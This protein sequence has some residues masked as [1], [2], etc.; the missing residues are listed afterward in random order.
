MGFTSTYSDIDVTDQY[1][2]T[3]KY[4]VNGFYND[5]TELGLLSVFCFNKWLPVA[6]I[7]PKH[8]QKVFDKVG[9]GALYLVHTP[10]SSGKKSLFY[11][12]KTGKLLSFDKSKKS[13]ISISQAESVAERMKNLASH[14]K[15][16]ADI[17]LLA[18][19]VI[20]SKLQ[21]GAS[22][23]LYRFTDNSWEKQETK[24]VVN[25]KLSFRSLYQDGIYLAALENDTQINSKRPFILI[26]GKVVFI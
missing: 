5:E 25:N 13:L 9:V 2:K 18:E 8:K 26:G 3:I 15:N 16:T 19:N 21:D 12:D 20:N 23:T 10:E 14:H 1:T 22:Y 17:R 24:P 4:N 7:S 11:V 6:A